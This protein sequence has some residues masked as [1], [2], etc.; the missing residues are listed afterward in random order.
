MKTKGSESK[1]KRKAPPRREC[2]VQR[3]KKGTKSPAKKASGSRGGLTQL[4]YEVL[5]LPAEERAVR[6]DRIPLLLRV[7]PEEVRMLLTHLSRRG[8]VE[9]GRL[10]AKDPAPWVWLTELGCN[11]MHLSEGMRYKPA[12]GQLE[13]I[14]AVVR[15]RIRYTRKHRKGLWV[16]ERELQRRHNR[17][18]CHLAD[19]LFEIPTKD[20]MKVIA[21]EVER[22]SKWRAKLVRN[23]SGLLEK[24]EYDEIHYLCSPYVKSEV[25]RA[26]AALI[27]QGV[28]V[29]KLTIL[30]IPDVAGIA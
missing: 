20:E 14:D 7:T 21:L 3:S 24:E 12:Y 29:E 2:E 19:A 16:P 5:S 18:K 8:L 26:R 15:T 17:T 25:E 27:E 30:D 4:H 13:H 1:A 28:G 6:K 9:Q 23:I 10:L 11:A 22:T